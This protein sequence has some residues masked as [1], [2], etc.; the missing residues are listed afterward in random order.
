MSLTVTM[1]Q[2]GESV[3]EGT[4]ENWLVAEGERVEKDQTICEITTD[5]VDAE[6]PAP[7]SG[8]ITRILAPEGATVEVG[9][10][11]AMIDPAGEA[12]AS[13]SAAPPAPPKAEAAPAPA[14]PAAA[15]AAESARV[16]PLA[17]R[18]AEERGISLDGMRGEDGRV[19]V[20]D[21]EAQ[22]AHAPASPP[23]TAAPAAPAA[24]AQ[25][26]AP[27]TLGEFLSNMKVPKQTPRE[28]DR[29]V[30]FTP[31]RRRVA[32]HMVVSKIVSP[33]VGTVAEIDLHKLVTLR[34]GA[35][36]A[37]KKTHGFS[38]T[39]LPF[40]VMATVRALREF[41]RMNSTVADQS[42]IERAAIHIG[43]AV[44]T[45]R[46]LVVPVV[47]D[48]DRLSLLGIAQA[49]EELAA[50]ARSRELTAD[51]LAGGTFTVSNPGRQ[52]NLYGF[53]VINQPQVGILRMGE[54]KKRAVVIE[55]EGQDTIAIRPS[56]YLSL[57]YDH[58][59][60][61]GVNGNGFL[62]AA[63]KHLEAAD[64]EL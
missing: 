37:F 10:E 18:V 59:V 21:V 64:F 45:D 5:K 48:T 38:L 61:D 15:D 34:E 50:K 44:Q 31:I 27:G 53:A 9:H 17:R 52:G 46:G 1:P 12:T 41:P 28:G 6:I 51:D 55:V 7:E 2:M 8:V 54:V 58:R 25:R 32:E 60:I 23:R 16:T 11:L 47:R 63:A 33:H 36:G 26:A 29:V 42:I 49:I 57:S 35:K 30:P 14:A 40:A 24:Q 62:Y 43:V 39:Y 4:I 3:V 19:R 22:G 20:A 13:P 56:M